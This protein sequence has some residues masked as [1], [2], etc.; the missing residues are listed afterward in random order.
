[1]RE[2]AVARHVH[3]RWTHELV[4]SKSSEKRPNIDRGTRNSTYPVREKTANYNI[5]QVSNFT[6]RGSTNAVL[7]SARP[8]QGEISIE[9]TIAATR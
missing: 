8:T 5:R 2:R 7:Q 3:G 6:G 1:M 4:R 9:R